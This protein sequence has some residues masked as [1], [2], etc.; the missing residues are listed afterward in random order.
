M[1]VSGCHFLQL[2]K[3]KVKCFLFFFQVG[4]E[5]MRTEYLILKL[6]LASGLR[7]RVDWVKR[8]VNE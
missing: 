5:L 1:V 4:L 8:R 3:I 2:G 7:T 6:Y